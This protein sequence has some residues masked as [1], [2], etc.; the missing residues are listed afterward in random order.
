MGF[1]IKKNFKDLENLIPKVRKEFLRQSKRDLK[2]LV[3]DESI[4]KGISPV[5]GQGKFEKYSKSYKEAI[6][7]GRYSQYSKTISPVNMKLSG[8]MLE[9]FFVEDNGNSLKIG[10]D[11]ELA[12]IHNDKGA[13]QSKV[14]RRL[15]PTKQGEKF[16]RSILRGILDLLDS[17]VAKILGK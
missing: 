8:D 10:F 16:K 6:K 17:A 14:I 5:E 7:A 15:L 1:K 9:S 12:E 3:I 11:H 13:G 2:K 4:S